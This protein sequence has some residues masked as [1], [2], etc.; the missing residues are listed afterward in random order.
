MERKWSETSEKD[1]SMSRTGKL[2]GLRPEKAEK[3]VSEAQME[4]EWSETSEKDFSISRVGKLAG[5]RD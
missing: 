1:F 2:A 4:L 5:L 3:A